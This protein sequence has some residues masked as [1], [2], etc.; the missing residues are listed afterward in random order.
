MNEFPK[1]IDEERMT[2]GM[3]R[4]WRALARKLVGRVDL[5][6]PWRKHLRDVRKEFGDTHQRLYRAS[7]SS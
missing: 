2:P 1:I 7:L 3:A 6:D 5:I 4:Y